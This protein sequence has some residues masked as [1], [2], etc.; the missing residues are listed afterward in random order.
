MHISKKI[1]SYSRRVY[2]QAPRNNNFKLG[3]RNLQKRNFHKMHICFC[4]LVY[5]MLGV[6]CKRRLVLDDENLHQYVQ[7]KEDLNDYFINRN[8]LHYVSDN[9]IKWYPTS[10]HKQANILTAKNASTRLYCHYYSKIYWCH[11]YAIQFFCLIS[12]LYWW[13]Y[14]LLT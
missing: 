9:Q 5:I 3:Y 6:Y 2:S 1:K 13:V 11:E 10:N 14:R 7:I 4:S 12:I 8:C